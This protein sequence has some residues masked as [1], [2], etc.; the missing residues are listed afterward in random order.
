MVFLFLFSTTKW[1]LTNI[2]TFTYGFR[3]ENHKKSSERNKDQDDKKVLVEENG[4]NIKPS[5]CILDGSCEPAA[6][7]FI[8]QRR[9]GNTELPAFD[10]KVIDG[11]Y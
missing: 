4:T 11:N 6:I 8:I 1:Q 3:Q 2:C 10:I 9:K 5:I 7:Y